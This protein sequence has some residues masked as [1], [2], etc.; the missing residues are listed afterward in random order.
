MLAE[1]DQ[2]L[3]HAREQVVSIHH[4]VVGEASVRN[5][6]GTFLPKR[7]GVVSGYIRSQGVPKPHQTKHFDVIIYDQ[8]ESPTLWIEDNR[9][10]SD[11][12]LT[13]IIPAEF[14]HAVFEVKAAFN[15]RTVGEA[16]AKLAE[17]KPLMAAIDT[18]TERYPRYLPSS[19]VLGMIFFE[20]RAV[21]QNDFEALD[22]LRVI[23]FQRGFY[24]AVI[25]RGNRQNADDA[26]LV[27]RLKS[28]TAI[29]ERPTNGLRHGMT[30]TATTEVNGNHLGA[31]IMW[32][33]VNFSRFA[34]DLLALLQGTYRQ[35][36]VSSFHGF[37]FSRGGCSF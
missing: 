16:L 19:A 3:T 21:D 2:A 22:L 20:L 10:K 9:D 33:D 4:G 34:F 6:L 5:W 11:M 13:R 23:D 37:D 14:V 25:F 1:Y 31:S 35:D 26:G 30:M 17:L 12:G 8:L 7:Y 15:K 24:G 29:A 27:T 36:F 28:D 18:D 32:S